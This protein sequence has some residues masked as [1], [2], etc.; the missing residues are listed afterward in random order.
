MILA[1]AAAARNTK[2]ATEPDFSRGLR[3]LSLWRDLAAELGDFELKS[4]ST[5]ASPANQDQLAEYGF[6]SAEQADYGTFRSMPGGSKTPLALM[7][8]P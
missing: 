1:P 2:N 6:D 7:P 3:S 8:R 4:A 5:P